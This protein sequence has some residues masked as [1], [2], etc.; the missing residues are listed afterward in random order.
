MFLDS[1]KPG[2]LRAM[3]VAVMGEAPR[4][5][6]DQ[7]AALALTLNDL[8][9]REGDAIAWHEDG[10]LNARVGEICRP[11]AVR[12]VVLPTV[13]EVEE[14]EDEAPLAPLQVVPMFRGAYQGDLFAGLGL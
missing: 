7:I 5:K 1:V 12:P 11:G 10:T 3:C 8:G 13:V 2:V 4:G 6:S 14:D 9:I